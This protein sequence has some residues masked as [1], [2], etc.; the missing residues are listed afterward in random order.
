MKTIF[1]IPGFK[2]KPAS[3]SF[4][5][6][7]KF[8]NEKNF[9]VK[10]VPIIWNYKTIT[11]YCLQFEKF[12]DENKGKEN[13]ILGFSYGAVIAYITAEKL[14]PKKIFLCSLSPD[15]K[16]DVSSMNNFIRCYIGKRRVKD[17]MT[18]SGKDIAKRLTLPTVIFY[19]EKEGEQ[20]PQLKKRCEETALLAKNAKLII[21]KD[22][23]HDI[24]NPE[25]MEAIKKQF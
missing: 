17:C 12:Y 23:L 3:K 6:L 19:G 11:D 21:V 20:Y 5:W 13:Y 16:E 4:V 15:F 22:S 14:Q 9:D 8:L 2:Q 7:K 18:R 25:Y 10:I 24:A 1:V